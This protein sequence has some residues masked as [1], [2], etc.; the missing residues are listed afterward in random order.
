MLEELRN[1]NKM[2]LAECDI[3][4]EFKLLKLSF[5]RKILEDDK[6]FFKMNVE[7]AYNI[8]DDLGYNKEEFKNIYANL[9]NIDNSSKE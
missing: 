1:K 4:D 7:D 8:F 9:M 5:I 3:D 6:C 2:L